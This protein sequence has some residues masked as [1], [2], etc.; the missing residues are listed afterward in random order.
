MLSDYIG[1]MYRLMRGEYI[2]LSI[3]NL[4][5]TPCNNFTEIDGLTLVKEIFTCWQ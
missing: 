3:Y 2:F 5:D 4:I 1:V